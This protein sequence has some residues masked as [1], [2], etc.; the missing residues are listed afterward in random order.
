[1]DQAHP[2]IPVLASYGGNSYYGFANYWG[3][4][5]GGLDLSTVADGYP[6]PGLTVT[7]Q[8]Q[9]NTT[10]YQLGKFGG[11]LT[12][13]S[14][15]TATLGALDGIPFSVGYDLT[16]LT[17]GNS[18]VTGANDWMIQWNS[19]SANFTVVGIQS[20][21]NNGCVVTNVTPVATVNAGAFDA[22]AISGF[23]NSYG[24]NITIPPT[25]GGAAHA[26][27]DPIFYFTQTAIVPGT[28][29][30]TLYCLNQCPTA[31]QLAGFSNGTLS[32]PFANGT[33]SQWFS[34]PNSSGTVTYTFGVSG[35]LDPSA[36]PIILEQANQ[37]PSGSNYA[38][39]GIQTGMLFTTPLTTANCPAGGPDA[40]IGNICEPANPT[41]YYTWQT[42]PQQ[43]N[44]SLWLTTNGSVVPFDPPQNIPYTVPSGAAYGS[45]AGLPI[46]LQFN[47]FGNLSGIPGYCVSAVDNSVQNCNGSNVVYMPMFSIP[48]GT[49]LSLPGLNLSGP[50][51][52]LIVKALNGEIL[53]ALAPGQCT[54]MP[55]AAQALP[56]G[57][58]HDPSN[59][60][61]SEYLGVMPTV[62]AAPKVINGVVQ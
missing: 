11:K 12:R 35:L 46:L 38:Q 3:M 40:A 7:D 20:C 26:A 42:G 59:P 51:T 33:D 23:A 24:G 58:L 2:G 16:G 45:W 10:S 18:I 31:T 5:F 36:A 6:I 53:L 17:S 56:S 62:T 52:P 44:Q 49:I 19:A 39:N 48:D 13:W 9:N 8:R 41:T 28:S 54:S 4:N 37:Y 29:V 57:G 60:S 21:S 15:Q 22:I 34:A 25:S 47:G 27:G 50:P 43:W 30:P 1:V 32:T 14:Q 55:L 61:D